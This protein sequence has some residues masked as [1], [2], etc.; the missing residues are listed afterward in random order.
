MENYEAILKVKD[1]L[2][3][4]GR[5]RA[6]LE[7]EIQRRTVAQ[8][9]LEELAAE[10]R[11]LKDKGWEE[12]Q[13]KAEGNTVAIRKLKEEVA[14]AE[15]DVKL[16]EEKREELLPEALEELREKYRPAYEKAFVQFVEKVKEA[17]V[18]ER[19]LESIREEANGLLHKVGGMRAQL[20]EVFPRVRR[21]TLTD[22]VGDLP[23]YS[24]LNRLL[25]DLKGLG[26][27]A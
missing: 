20:C 1:A 25:E 2:S 15:P 9:E 24:P 16:L 26:L 8:R 23:E 27:K 12:K 18:L 6:P 14:Q 7:E 21:I 10:A 11:L 13:A 3:E 22:E 17:N 19:Q 5:R 4:I